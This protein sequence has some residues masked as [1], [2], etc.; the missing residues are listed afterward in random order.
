MQKQ[1][2]HD[3]FSIW[4]PS[5]SRWDRQ[6][7]FN[8]LPEWLHPFVTVLC[9]HNEVEQYRN[10]ES[11]DCVTGRPE[12]VDC[13]E[14]AWK[15]IFEQERLH[16][17]N[18]LFFIL[19]DDLSFFRWKSPDDWHLRPLEKDSQDFVKMFNH[20][21]RARQQGYGHGTL[22]TRQG[23]NQKFPHATDQVGRSNAFHWYSNEL[24]RAYP[25]ID[26]SK[27]GLQ[28]IHATLELLRRGHPN[29]LLQEF[30]WNQVKGGNAP[31]GCSTYRDKA[32]QHE[33]VM[34]LKELH[35][36]FVK[37]MEKRPKQGWDQG[38]DTR[39][40]VTVYWKKAYASSSR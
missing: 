33:H 10:S 17:H 22:T 37:V 1:L 7:T 38:M 15:F 16:P 19:D 14:K 13:L 3:R 36:D 32:W 4:I 12:W 30:C 40:D 24:L 8:N 35:P 11:G 39:T 5:R 18:E 21:L 6:Y 25:E 29:F 34:R 28:D 2:L 23:N 26:P 31:G 27:T 20:F 9:P